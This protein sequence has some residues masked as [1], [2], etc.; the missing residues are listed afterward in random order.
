MTEDE[1]RM[2]QKFARLQGLDGEAA[3][4]DPSAPDGEWRLYRES[5]DSRTDVTADVV[6]ALKERVDHTEPEPVS[7][8]GFIIR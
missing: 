8:R 2:V 6:R 4:V 3:P 1:A 7:T 5:V